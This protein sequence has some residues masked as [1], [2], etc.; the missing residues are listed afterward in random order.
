MKPLNKAI[1]AAKIQGEDWRH[2]L[3]RFLLSYRATP[4]TS[5]GEPPAE[6]L[7]NRVIRSGVPAISEQYTTPVNVAERN[8]RVE[9]KM[10]QRK[11][12]V[13]TYVDKTRG[14]KKINVAV[15]DT[16]LLR[17]SKTNK[18]STLY[19]PE[20]YKIISI[21]G[22]S[23]TARRGEKSITRHISFMKKFG[24]TSKQNKSKMESTDE[25]ESSENT[26]GQ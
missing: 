15:G 1:R 11:E 16:V 4:H 3:Y 24:G 6:L 9:E 21:K 5:T 18:F 10:K 17:Q 26:D 7:F 25:E 23:V 22:R 13:K 14:A 2:V 12:K 20:P 8:K 19:D